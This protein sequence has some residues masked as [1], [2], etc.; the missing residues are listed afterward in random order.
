MLTTHLPQGRLAVVARFLL[1][2]IALNAAVRLGLLLFNGDLGFFAPNRLLPIFGIGLLFDLAAAVWWLFPFLLLV[3]LWP[4]R[5]HRSFRWVAGSLLLIAS[6][7]LAF[8]AA[9]EFFFWNEFASRFNFIA[10]D[11]LVYT[12]EVIGNIRESYD[13]RPAF[14]GIA[15]VTAALFAAQWRPL[16]DAAQGEALSRRQRVAIVVAAFVLPVLSFY[17]VQPRYKEFTDEAQAVQLAG[18]GHYEFWSAFRNNEIDYATF[19]RSKPLAHVYKVLRAEYEQIGP[20]RFTANA[21]MPIEREVLARGPEKRL[22]VVLVTVESLSADFMAAFGN[23]KALT[24]NLDRLAQESLF[25]TRLYATGLRT[26]RGLEAVTLS[27]PPT[28]GNSVVKRPNNGKLFT[29]GEVFNQ[30][31]YE[32][33]Y[34]YGGYGYFD[35]MQDFF[36]GNGYTVIDRLAIAKE[37]IHHETIWGVADEDLFTQTLQQLDQRHAAGK[38]FYAHVMTTSNHRPYTYPEGRIDIPSGSGRNGAVKYTDWAIGEFLRQAK[39]R[40]WFDDTVFVILADHTSGGRGKTALTIEDFHIPLMIW[41]PRHI[42]PA[43]VDTLASQIDVGPTLLALLNVSYRSRF[44]GHDILHEGPAHQR[45]FM[46]N[47]QT[48]GYLENGILVELRPQRRW[49]IVDAETGKE[50]AADE[51]GTRILDEAVSHYQAAAEAYR[52]GALVVPGKP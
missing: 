8:V 12:R 10:V 35:N 7:A 37:N 41:S 14:A 25:F 40:P 4:A 26:V 19:Y 33:L 39:T 36:G 9:S 13:L 27:F 51:Q 45:A 31:G 5:A 18:N 52:S 43:R 29:L 24:P 32:S 42:K 16:R 15:L 21:P 44:F 46:A 11:Y 49:R 38:R 23:D 30:R 34:L 3:A 20:Q 50:R 2:L 1:T 17:L 48:V 6:G 28:P 22:N 47:Y